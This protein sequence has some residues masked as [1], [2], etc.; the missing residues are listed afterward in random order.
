MAGGVIAN[1]IL[2]YK[3]YEKCNV[4]NIFICPSMGDEGSAL[5]AAIIAAIEHKLDLSWLSKYKLPY[6]GT[7]FSKE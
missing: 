7:S 5:G 1:V 3:I 6:W 4:K 2:N